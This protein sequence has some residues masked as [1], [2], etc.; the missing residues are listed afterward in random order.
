MNNVSR[1]PGAPER[2]AAEFFNEQ[3]SEHEF[4]RHVREYAKAHGWLD[5]H[6]HIA[7]RSTEGFPDLVLV[8]GGRLVFAELK[9]EKKGRVSPAQAR[10]IEELSVVT[11]AIVAALF[12]SGQGPVYA[13][14]RAE[15]IVGAYLWKPSDWPEIERVL[16]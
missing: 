3:Q 6:T 1:F 2:E 14:E 12:D 9:R 5:Y 4:M 13:A 8:R 11:Q 15:L 7:K 10:W 16:A